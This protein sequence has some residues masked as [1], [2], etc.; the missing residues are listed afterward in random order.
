VRWVA[1]EVE[2]EGRGGE[3]ETAII[4]QHGPTFYSYPTPI[5]LIEIAL[6]DEKQYGPES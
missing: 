6:R 2:V 1:V 5:N 4:Q 3:V